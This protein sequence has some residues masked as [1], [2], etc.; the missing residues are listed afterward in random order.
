MNGVTITR[1]TGTAVNTAAGGS[2]NANKVWA[3][4]KI[5]IAPDAT[6]EVG[7]S[8]TFTVTL[9]KD[10]GAGFV[11]AAGEHVDFTLTDSNGA[12]HTAATGTCTN[13]G[14]NTDAAGQCTIIFSSPTAGKV[15]G[16]ASA[17]LTIGGSATVHG[18][19]QRR[20]AELG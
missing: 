10:N 5:E 3:S 6:N 20:G 1:T 14:P 12:A 17:T 11:P 8:H 13:A 2:D 19:D 15:T 9:S 18:R 7:Q 4:A 16:H